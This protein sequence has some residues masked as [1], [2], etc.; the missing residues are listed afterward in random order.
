MIN[1]KSVKKIPVECEKIE[2]YSLIELLIAL[3]ILAIMV[4][5]L[6]A[7]LGPFGQRR[8][9]TSDV[10]KLFTDLKTTQQ[11]A[12]VKKDSYKYYGLRF[13]NYNISVGDFRDGYKIV[14]YEPQNNVSS[15]DMNPQ[16]VPSDLNLNVF[17]IIQSSVSA[18]N[19][20]FLENTFF[21]RKVGI[22]AS[23]EFRV[24]PATPPKLDAIVFTPEGS[25]TRDGWNLLNSTQDDIMLSLVNGETK[26][27]T[28]TP[29]TGYLKIQ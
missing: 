3:G 9:L 15:L 18:E 17:T 19:P 4:G 28:I 13:Y 22:D 16:A 20:Q 21:D 27:I 7:T 24:T 10:F 1:E 11:F 26:K 5:T 14:R 25:A 2:G 12:R 29:L 6:T 23:S 8:Q